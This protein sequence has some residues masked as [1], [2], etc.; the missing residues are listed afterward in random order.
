[1]LPLPPGGERLFARTLVVFV[2]ASQP[3]QAAFDAALALKRECDALHVVHWRSAD[4]LPTPSL[5]FTLD[6][7]APDADARAKRAQERALAAAAAVAA[8]E[9]AGG[10][11]AAVM[12]AA[13]ATAAGTAAP[14]GLGSGA[15]S[16]AD[17]AAAAAAA[18]ADAC[19]SDPVIAALRERA[20]ATHSHLCYPHTHDGRDDR[21]GDGRAHAPAQV[22]VHGYGHGS[23]T[24]TVPGVTAAAVA[25]GAATA[26]ARGGAPSIFFH[27]AATV[28]PVAAAVRY[29]RDLD[30]DLVVMGTAQRSALSRL[31]LGT[32]SDALARNCDCDVYIARLGQRLRRG[33]RIHNQAVA[34]QDAATAGAATGGNGHEAPGKHRWH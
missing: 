34:A 4:A 1:M 11:G 2:D 21:D 14:T 26:A 10:A 22:S 19:A 29:V 8:G 16:G 25:A 18:T 5:G 33:H 13:A 15:D 6:F 23:T 7:A 12:A 17:A 20:R 3:A 30:P 9:A 28:T 24:T 32:F 27:S 31:V